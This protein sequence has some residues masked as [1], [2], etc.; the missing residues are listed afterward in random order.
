MAARIASDDGPW[1]ELVYMAALETAA[2]GAEATED[3]VVVLLRIL[4]Y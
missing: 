3:D 1:S 2:G 4:R